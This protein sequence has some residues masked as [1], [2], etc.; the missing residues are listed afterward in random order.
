MLLLLLVFVVVVGGGQKRRL[1]VALHSNKNM[2]K[3]QQQK[4]YNNNAVVVVVAAAVKLFTLLAQHNLQER[5]VRRARSS[6]SCNSPWRSI[7]LFYPPSPNFARS[8]SLALSR[9]H[10]L[11]ASVLALPPV[12]VRQK[13]KNQ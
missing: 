4:N 9:L 5:I 8:L 7:H 3:I 1:V 2:K 11:H 6:L 13:W 10:T 12:S